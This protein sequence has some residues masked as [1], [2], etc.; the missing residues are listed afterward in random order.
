MSFGSYFV[1]FGH[2]DLIFDPILGFSVKN[3]C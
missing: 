2:F 1:N 3:A